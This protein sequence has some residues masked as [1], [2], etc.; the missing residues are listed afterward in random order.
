[1]EEQEWPVVLIFSVIFIFHPTFV[2]VQGDGSISESESSSGLSDYSFDV[3]HRNPCSFRG[4][5]LTHGQSITLD[6]CTVCTCKNGTTTCNIESCLSDIGCPVSE[7]IFIEGECC[8]LCPYKIYIEA[9]EV[10]SD[11]KFHFIEGSSRNITFDLNII[12]NRKLSSRKVQG[13]NLWK[14]GAWMSVNEDGSGTKY[15][16]KENIFNTKE[17]SKSWLKSTYPPWKWSKLRYIPDFRDDSCAACEVFCLEFGKGDHPQPTYNILFELLAPNNRTNRLIDCVSV[18]IYKAS[19][20]EESIETSVGLLTFPSTEVNLQ[21]KSK[22]FCVSPD[23]MP[24]GSRKCKGDLMEAARWENPIVLNCFKKSSTLRDNIHV[25]VQQFF[26]RVEEDDVS[27]SNVTY[28]A[29]DLTDITTPGVFRK[30]YIDDV[31]IVLEKVVNVNST[32]PKVTENVVKTIDNIITTTSINEE[33]ILSFRTSGTFLKSLEKQLDTVKRSGSNFSMNTP[34]INVEVVQIQTFDQAT[35]FAS[36]QERNSNISKAMLNPDPLF[37][38]QHRIQ[39]YIELPNI[40][41]H[42]SQDCL[43]SENYSQLSLPVAFTIHRNGA[44]FSDSQLAKF[45]LKRNTWIISASPLCEISQLPNGSFVY[46]Q[47]SPLSD[48]DLMNSRSTNAKRSLNLKHKFEK[49]GTCVFWDHDLY[50]RGSG[51]W[52]PRGC[53]KSSTKD[54]E[55]YECVCNHLPKFA[56]FAVLIDVKG[57][58]NSLPLHILT[59]VGCVTSI[60][61]LL[62]TIAFYLSISKLRNSQPKRIL[63]NLCVSLLGLYSCFLIGIKWT[64]PSTACIIFGGLIHFFCLS[65]VAWMSVEATQLYL[66]FVKVINTHVTH[67]LMKA[68]LVSWGIPFGFVA[69]SVAIGK[70]SY[71]HDYC[72]PEHSSPWFIFGV[73]GLIGVPQVYNIILYI[74]II[75]NILITRKKISESRTNR[76]GL[77]RRLQNAFA[78][79]V[80]VG[81]TWIFGFFAIGSLRMTFNVL[82]CLFNSFQ[83]FFIFLLFCIRQEEVRAALRKWWIILNWRSKENS[84]VTDS[85]KHVSP[86]AKSVNFDKSMNKIDS[87]TKSGDKQ[88]VKC[89]YTT[90]SGEVSLSVSK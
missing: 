52:S 41:P 77:L 7:F 49:H 75:W 37:L 55:L 28:I 22:E 43:L 4:R 68:S 89:S 81:L 42:L 21:A 86:N 66:L 48:T 39:L 60:V 44:L 78:I 47:F 69:L 87:Q 38:E 23:N 34:N 53:F 29:H 16:Y 5:F 67:F 61:S 1:M 56:N 72:F 82:F 40:I 71:S 19:C 58:I 2:F 62:I 57:S 18:G 54:S 11:R 6:P 74:I 27:S 76:G 9:I 84:S 17:A 8:P 26:K 88:Q 12:V 45:N 24:R 90:I 73:V 15:L 10:L 83:G 50:G 64:E 3:H 80:L 46:L 13:E 32:L 30:E 85:G 14:L 70:D 33:D 31:A 35:S 25:F 36:F 20:M 79:S 51:G 65:S 59:I 63:L